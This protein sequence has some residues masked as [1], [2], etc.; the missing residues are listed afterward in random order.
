MYIVPYKAKFS[1]SV[2]DWKELVRI[3]NVTP[4]LLKK[5]S[6]F[7]FRLLNSAFDALY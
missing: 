6:S 2:V 4:V 5:N 1:A 3:Q 7:V